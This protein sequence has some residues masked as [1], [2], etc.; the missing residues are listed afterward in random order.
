MNDINKPM[1]RYVLSN[2]SLTCL[3]SVMLSHK[4]IVMKRM[5]KRIA[6]NIK[7]IFCAIPNFFCSSLIK[8]VIH[9][10]CVLVGLNGKAGYWRI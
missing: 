2:V 4:D 7:I 1:T 8:C 5:L 3:G 9:F 10:S 6:A